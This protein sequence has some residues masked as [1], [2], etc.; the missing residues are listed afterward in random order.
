MIG[1]SGL[2]V[3]LR[4]HTNPKSIADTTT[5]SLNHDEFKKRADIDDMQETEKLTDI[6]SSLLFQSVKPAAE[7]LHKLDARAPLPPICPGDDG[8]S[9]TSFTGGIPDSIGRWFHPNELGHETIASF[10]LENMV[11]ARAAILDVQNPACTL[12][13]EFKCWKVDGR[14]AYAGAGVMNK[15]I[16][17]FCDDVKQP[18]R[19]VGWK[20]EKTFHEGSP[21]EHTFLLQLT[22][23]AFEFDKDDCLSSFDKIVNG[24]KD[25]DDPENPMAWRFGGRYVQDA[26][27]YEVNVKRD[28]RPWPP[29]KATAGKCEGWY[30]F[31]F[32]AYKL[33]GSGWST[34]DKGEETI[35]PSIKGCLGLGITKWDFKYFDAP[36]RD[37]ME[38]QLNFNTPIWVRARCFKNQKVAIASGGSTDGCGGND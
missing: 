14:H 16:K 6:Y 37:G 12:Q 27:T 1:P 5:S 4:S 29:I 9:W 32:S 17:A 13:D 22:N 21:D 36:D 28:N 8:V 26:Y 38:W 31:L 35:K 34:W 30:K 7:A 15:N 33:K 10:A 2:F 20:W 23:D 25:G 24:C 3:S 11:G 19:T 18:D